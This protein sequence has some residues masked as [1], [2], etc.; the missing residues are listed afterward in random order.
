MTTVKPA[1]SRVQAP[2]VRIPRP[3]GTAAAAVGVLA[4]LTALMFWQ[5]LFDGWTFPWDFLGS[6]ETTPPFVA[7][8]ASNWSLPAWMPY[9]ASG[10]PTAID[11]QI[12]LY[13][14]I[15]WLFGLLGIPL[16][17]SAQ[18]DVQ[19]FH[20][21]FGALGA[22]ALARARRLDWSWALVAAT[23]YLFFGGFYGESQH[24]DAVRG[25]AYLPWLL[26]CLTPP[27]VGGRWR[28]L[29]WLVPLA[30]LIVAG[31]YPAH[32]VSFG[33]IGGAY[34][35]VALSVQ[36]RLAWRR[37]LEP[38][39]FA[40]AAAAAIAVAILLPY[41]IAVHANQLFR[42]SPP[43]QANRVAGSLAVRDFLGL[44]LSPFAWNQDGS[45]YTWSV[46]A[47]ILIGLACVRG[48]SLRRHLPLLAAGL[49]ALALA[50]TPRFGP[51]GRLMADFPTL[52]P[53][54]FPAVDYKAGVAVAAVIL[55]AEGWASA[56]RGDR[57]SRWIAAAVGLLLL[58]GAL[59]AP[60]THGQPTYALWLLAI[61]IAECVALVWWRPP[62]RVLLFALI[63]LIA[64]D[65][66]R[67]AR[68]DRVGTV[69]AWQVDS[70]TAAHF[71]TRDAYLPG[72]P[73][74]LTGSVTSRPARVPPVGLLSQ[75]PIGTDDDAVGWLAGGYHFNDYSSTIET[76][77][78]A[79]E[80]RP[81]FTALLLAP[82]RA[83]VFPCAQVSCR[84]GS[85]HLPSPATWRPATTVRTL[86]YG[87]SGVTYAVDV[88][89][90]SLMVENELPLDGWQSSSAR[91]TFVDARIP[92]RAWRIAAGRYVFKASY[93]QPGAT[94]QELAALAALLL[95][96][97]LAA[98]LRA[99]HRSPGSGET[100]GPQGGDSG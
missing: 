20:V 21:L 31:A 18:T 93:V 10:F 40:A 34:V 50:M 76:S 63:A 37:W 55:G 57:R 51:I 79:A 35:V 59:I 69:S 28:R 65:G 22:L 1:V 98:A 56:V 38:L 29:P 13:Y 52:F 66:Y 33:I 62:T 85:V 15:W 95:F 44:Y 96:A 97:C 81:F 92:L 14:P 75:F 3:Y 47:P 88:S 64:V 78:H 99:R 17:L 32:V 84:S 46:G 49:V 70:A 26:W 72:L 74:A 61:V 8:A 58:G 19:V 2:A 30:W 94:E 86:A 48:A 24:P 6:Y 27:E 11:P 23:A 68:D 36:G 12:G 42:E 100:P 16:T 77:L 5:H 45:V 43:T 71:R 91:A 9:V 7:A 87:V 41:F 89:R 83:Y 39:L 82:W 80:Q 60:S 4:V 67:A 54:R 90:P 73:A 25:F 53:S